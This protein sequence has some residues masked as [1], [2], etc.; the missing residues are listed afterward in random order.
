MIDKI[1][2]AVCTAVHNEFGDYKI[3][4]EKVEQGFTQPCFSV[5]CIESG[6]RVFLGKRYKSTNKIQVSLY[7]DGDDKREVIADMAERLP[8]AI[9]Y[10]TVDGDV[11]RCANINTQKGDEGF[12]CTFDVDY[13]F[14][15][16]EEKELMEVMD[17][18]FEKK[19]LK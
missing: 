18:F 4:T 13:F 9:E 17:S 1:I 19:N 5:M 11:M 15:V 16:K 2:K 3:Y 7:A 14:Y 8:M 12:V 6:C 10:I